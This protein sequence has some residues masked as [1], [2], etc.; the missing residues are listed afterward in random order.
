MILV[1][2]SVWIDHLRTK[3]ERL[4]QLLLQT[5]VCTHPMIWGELA[6]GSLK[7]RA[8]LLKLWENL[9]AIKPASHAEAMYC[10]E[11]RQLMGRGIGYVD[12]H[13]LTAVLLSPGTVLWTR[14]KRLHGIAS[15]LNCCWQEFH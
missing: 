9:P 12:L 1:D 11:Q 7:N 2:T 4:A 5:Q 13:L 14:D 3:D 10:L 6:C 8:T 15:E